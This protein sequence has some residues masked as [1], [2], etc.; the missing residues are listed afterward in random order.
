MQ[1]SALS[2]QI[3]WQNGLH[4][5]HYVNVLWG[6]LYIYNVKLKH[7]AQGFQSIS[8]AIYCRKNMSPFLL[9]LCLSIPFS[10][11]LSPALSLKLSVCFRAA[12]LCLR[13]GGAI[14]IISTL[15]HKKLDHWLDSGQRHR[16]TRLQ[17]RLLPFAHMRVFKVLSVWM[18]MCVFDGVAVC[19]TLH[20]Q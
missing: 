16:I 14:N 10:L 12:T 15:Q 9:L 1:I 5:I 2:K 4:R 17:R 3:Q 19:W 18:C 20:R 6:N 7:Y 11:H 8:S 13:P